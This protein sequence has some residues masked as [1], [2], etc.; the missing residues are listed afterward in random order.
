MKNQ[1]TQR[2]LQMHKAGASIE[3]MA[4]VLHRSKKD[5]V[6]VLRSKGIDPYANVRTCIIGQLPSRCVAWL[7]RTA[8]LNNLSIDEMATAVMRDALELCIEEDCDLQL[9]KSTKDFEG[10]IVVSWASMLA[11]RGTEQ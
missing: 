8:R 6:M 5:I 4:R 1:P 3:E 10:P 11:T 7:E 2:I 9:R